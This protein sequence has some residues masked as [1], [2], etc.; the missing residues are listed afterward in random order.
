V[1]GRTGFLRSVICAVAGVAGKTNWEVSNR[2]DGD[3]FVKFDMKWQ[4]GIV[5]RLQGLQKHCRIA[6]IVKREDEYR[7][8][9][10]S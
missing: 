4:A 1:R 5:W 6:G 10:K 2:S 9:I 3:L 8:M 7:A